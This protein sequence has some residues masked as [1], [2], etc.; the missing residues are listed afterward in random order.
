MKFNSSKW[1]SI[2]QKEIQFSDEI[3]PNEIDPKK[4]E[5]RYLF[6][7]VDVEDFIEVAIL[8]DFALPIFR[9]V[10]PDSLTYSVQTRQI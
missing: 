3:P 10:A 7:N 5:N 2:Y 1:N 9:T 8:A 6:D 4:I